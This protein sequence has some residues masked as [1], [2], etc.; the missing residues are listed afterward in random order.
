MEEQRVRICDIAEELGLSTATVSNVIHGK[1]KKIS[2]ETVRRVMALLEERQYIPNL[3]EILLAQNSSK[4]IGVFIND[5]EKYEGHTLD[6]F[7]IASSLNYLST[8]IENS[9][10]FMMVKK[11]KCAEE[12]I[13]FA[14]MWNMDGIVI[15][16][17]CDQDYMYLRNHM[18]IPFVVYDGFCQNPDRIVNITIDNFD[19]GHQIGSHF[20][21]LGHKKALCISDNE[22]GVDQERLE[23]FHKGFSPGAVDFLVI[24]MRKDE[25]W[26]FYLKNLDII[27]NVTAVF[28]PSDYYAIDMMCFL[29]EQGI[30]VPEDISIAGFDDIPMC[31]MVC[32]PLT[33]VRQDGAV[34]ARLAIEK[35]KELREKKPVDAEIRLPV[36]LVIRKSTRKHE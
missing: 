23:G 8:E 18:R 36:S 12:I 21:E 31:R 7:F 19:G 34:R 15:I 9:N 10:Q 5:H 29:N 27:R 13:K 1:T 24:P 2:D 3:A 11:A 14:S 35:L 30:S 6:D 33:S 26:T 32:P 28:A 22:I 25:R 20:R 4:I 16:G 17:F